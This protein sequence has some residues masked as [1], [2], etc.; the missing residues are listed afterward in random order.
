MKLAIELSPAESKQLEDIAT[1]MGVPIEELATAAISDLVHANSE[2]FENA[3]SRILE[4]NRE[5]YK[6]LS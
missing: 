1:T 2:D 6:R 4:K 5:L 3:A